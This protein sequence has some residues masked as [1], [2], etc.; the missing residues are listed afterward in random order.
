MNENMKVLHLGKYYPPFFGGMEKMNY[1][2]VENMKNK[3]ECEQDV[4]C[5]SHSKDFVETMSTDY[6]LYRL[7]LRRVI[8]STPIP[9]GVFSLYKKIRNDYDIIYLHLPNPLLSLMVL[10]Y[11]TKAKLIAHWQGDIMRHRFFL[12]FYK[13]FQYLMLKRADC[14][15]VTSENYAKHSNPL[16]RFQDKIKVIP[17]GID[18]SYL[19]AT[20]S[21]IDEVKEKYK[22][23]RIV[24]S[25]GRLT[26]YK[27]FQYLVDAA[28]FLGDDT[29][30]LI[31]GVGELESSLQNQIN[32]QDLKERVKLI[33]RV[34]N[35]YMGAYLRAADVYCL[36]SITKAEGYGIVLLEAMSVGTPIV[37]SNLTDSAACWINQ[38]G[39][40]GY[41]VEKKNSKEIANGIRGILEDNEKRKVFSRNC[42]ERYKNV[43]TLD[44][45][46][47]KVY[48]M[49]K[50]LMKLD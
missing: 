24:L 49:Y 17:I 45:M 42:I 29:V 12:F 40:T 30:V 46:L 34:P 19:K 6:K 36:P 39:V 47:E 9:K 31:A 5:C 41:N 33:G 20:Q 26:P 13:P 25:I 8:A 15:V 22:G 37:A 23:K 32:D 48:A 10:L 43:F 2:I 3:Y 50:E 11:P 4:L 7:P 28:K 1:D 16:R 44:E 27:G 14:I 18:N 35:G 21:Q 38:D